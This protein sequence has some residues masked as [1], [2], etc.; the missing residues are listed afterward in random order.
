MHTATVYF[1]GPHGTERYTAAPPAEPAVSSTA[2]L[3][4][5]E[6]SGWEGNRAGRPGDT[7]LALVSPCWL[8]RVGVTVGRVHVLRTVMGIRVLS[9]RRS[10]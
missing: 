1:I 4:P 6:I 3:P 10:A 7:R 5:G 8:I 2:N 9:A